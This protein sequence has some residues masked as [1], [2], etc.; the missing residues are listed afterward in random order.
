MVGP[1]PPADA[2][3]PAAPPPGNPPG[4]PPGPLGIPPPAPWYSLVTIGMQTFS[5]SFCLC[6]N[7][8]FSA[9]WN[10]QH[11][12]RNITISMVRH[13]LNSLCTGAPK[14]APKPELH[15]SLLVTMPRVS[16]MLG[17]MVWQA[18]F[19]AQ[20]TFPASSVSSASVS[21][22][23]FVLNYDLMAG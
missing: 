2:P 22:P 11:H 1:F 12:Y 10:T 13:N 19:K 21:S 3:P 18:Q 20:H 14:M 4:N 8:S 6:S 23:I 9:S 15:V 5:N 16:D 17:E 7:S